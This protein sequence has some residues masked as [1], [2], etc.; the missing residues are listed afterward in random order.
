[1]T[2]ELSKADFSVEI[3]GS[4]LELCFCERVILVLKLSMIRALIN[5]WDAL[6]EGR[7]ARK[8]EIQ[9]ADK[10]VEVAK[11]DVEEIVTAYQS[12]IY[13]YTRTKKTYKRSGKYW[14]HFEKAAATV[15]ELDI[16][17]DDYISMLFTGY[18]EWSRDATLSIPFPNQL[19]GETAEQIIMTQLGKRG[20][21]LP[22]GLA[23]RRKAI[24][25]ARLPIDEDSHYADI[26]RR[27]KTKK[28][29]WD[30]LE[31]VRVRQM[32]QY[33]EVADWLDRYAAELKERER[34]NGEED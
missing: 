31:Y 30:D 15:R 3:R 27:F 34:D 5:S 6:S 26:R 1:M 18:S 11:R 9:L 19:H 20:T 14:P 22:G 28:Y 17:A 10:S 4:N 13:R 29:S 16:S 25:N 33:G 23:G 21:A 2:A 8:K 12:L 24:K 32:Q 7:L